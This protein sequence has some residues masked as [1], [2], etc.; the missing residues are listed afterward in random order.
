MKDADRALAA[1]RDD[2]DRIA[3]YDVEGWGHNSHYHGLLLR[4]LPAQFG[5]ALEVGCGTGSFA[6]LLAR[7]ADR[8]LGIDLSPEMIRIARER[9]LREANIDF[10]V[11]DVME[12]RLPAEH[13]DVITSIATLHHV[14][15]ESALSRLAE[16]VRPGR[17][18]VVLDLYERKGPID[19]ALDLVAIPAHLALSLARRGRLRESREAARLWSE[20]GSRDIY[21]S[22]DEIR[23][24]ASPLLP[25]SLV[26]RHLFW[27]YSL[28]WKKGTGEQR[29]T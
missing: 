19:R 21:M 27:R 24:V 25:G 7:R 5:R 11:S 15:F 6:R 2:F 10:E 17:T 20:H 4:Q 9:S 12:R 8:V 1:V 22:F 26:R 29:K 3:Q 28:V 16:A 13:F 23:R 14:P 18:L